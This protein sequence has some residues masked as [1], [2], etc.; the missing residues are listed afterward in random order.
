MLDRSKGKGSYYASGCYRDM[1]PIVMQLGQFWSVLIGI[2]MAYVRF[3]RDLPIPPGF[4][5][6]GLRFVPAAHALCMPALGCLSTAAC[7]IPYFAALVSSRTRL[8]ES[9]VL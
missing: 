9:R 3:D 4:V 2:S 7:C 6:N 8:T 1:Q 5:V